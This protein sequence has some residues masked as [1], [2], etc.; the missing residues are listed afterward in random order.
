M[1]DNRVVTRCF[2]SV[3]LYKHK[4]KHNFRALQ[5]PSS[6]RSGL[7]SNQLKRTQTLTNAPIWRHRTL[8]RIFVMTKF[9]TS[10][11]PNYLSTSCQ[12][13]APSLISFTTIKKLGILTDSNFFPTFK[14][15]TTKIFAYLLFSVRKLITSSNALNLITTLWKIIG[16]LEVYFSTSSIRIQPTSYPSSAS[17]QE[18]HL[19]WWTWMQQTLWQ[20]YLQCLETH[21][22]SN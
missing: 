19:W 15:I 17:S 5:R 6:V 18:F 13:N 16:G 8:K 11:P 10:M 1:N 7:T 21:Q 14:N 2:L 9:F 12:D 3:Q 4:L 20:T 22:H